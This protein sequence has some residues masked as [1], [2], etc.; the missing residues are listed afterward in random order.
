MPP[1]NEFYLASYEIESNGP[2]A[3]RPL[4][5]ASLLEVEERKE[6]GEFLVGPEVTKW[7]PNGRL[8]FPRAATLARMA[9]GQTEFGS[10]QNLQ[11]IYLRETQ[12]VKAPPP[13]V[14]PSG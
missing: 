1:S 11:P 3:V 9:L 5:L 4:R 10:A 6:E 8:V 13:R 14:L 7:F 2:H 12:F